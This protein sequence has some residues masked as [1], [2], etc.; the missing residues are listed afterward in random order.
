MMQIAAEDDKRILLRLHE[1]R[2]TRKRRLHRVRSEAH[3]LVEH[4]RRRPRAAQVGDGADFGE[5]HGALVVIRG[6]VLVEV[7][8]HLR[9]LLLVSDPPFR[10]GHVMIRAASKH[11]I[12]EKEDRRLDGALGCG[13]LAVNVEDR[14]PPAVLHRPATGSQ[15]TGICEA[16][17]RLLQL[18]EQRCWQHLLVHGCKAAAQAC[19]VPAGR[20]VIEHQL[21]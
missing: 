4:Q 19:G 14:H 20:V 1:Q 3:R 21:R 13:T 11:Q 5:A 18:C 12:E 2:F 16:R 8:V 7:E 9:R 15:R 10:A 17:R 6:L